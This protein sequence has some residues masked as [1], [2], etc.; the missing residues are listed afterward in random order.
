MAQG[1][2]NIAFETINPATEEKLTKSSFE[3][4]ILIVDNYNKSC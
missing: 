1:I 2:K 4:D 3:F